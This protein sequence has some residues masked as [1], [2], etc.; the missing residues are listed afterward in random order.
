[1]ERFA[2]ITRDFTSQA[3]EL[4]EF[5]TGLPRTMRGVNKVKLQLN[6]I[7]PVLKRLPRDVLDVDLGLKANAMEAPVS[8]PSLLRRQQQAAKRL[9]AEEQHQRELQAIQNAREGTVRLDF[10]LGGQRRTR[11]SKYRKGTRRYRR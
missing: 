8:S 6:L 2:H 1:M 5:L 9:E 3:E 7:L 10:G 11:R 4:K